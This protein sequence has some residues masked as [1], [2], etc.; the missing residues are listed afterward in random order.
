MAFNIGVNVVEVD[1]SA[2]PTIVAAPISVAGFLISSLRGIP[3][4]PVHLTGFADFVSS[5]GSYTPRFYG[6]HAARGF[7]D[8]GGTEAYAVRVVGR[9]NAAAQVTLDDPTAVASL[10]VKA[11][12]HGLADPGAWGNGLSVAVLDN[13]L[14]SSDIPAQIVGASSEPFALTDGD[15]LSVEVNGGAPTVVTFSAPDFGNI[16]AATAVEVATVVARSTTAF[17]A[18]VTPGNGL[19][20]ASSG[21]GLASRLAVSGPAAASLG[22]TGTTANSDT[23]LA[24]GTTSVALAATG[25]F[26]P[27]SAVRLESRG[28]VVGGAMAAS[29]TSGAGITITPDGGSGV[30]VTFTDADFAHGV[31]AI[32]P[33][34]VVAA[35]NRQAVGFTAGLT[36]DAHLVLC[37]DTFGHGSTIALAPPGGTTPDATA[38]LGLTGLTPVAGSRAFA[39]LSAVSETDRL[40]TLGT[41]LAGPVPANESRIQSIEFDL[42]VLQNGSEIERFA[43]L[44]MQSALATY[45]ETMVN[46]QDRGSRFV[47]VTDQHSTS[48]AGAGAPAVTPAPV[49]LTGGSDGST[50]S[51][52]DFMGDPAARTGLYAFDTVAIQL[53]CCPETTSAGV[54]SAA[55]AYCAGRGDAMFIGT[56]PQGYDLE[57]IKTY[58]APLRARKVYGALYAPWIQ[59]INPLDTTGANPQLTIPPVGHVAGM[60][61]RVG[62]ASGVW[63]A[64]AGDDAGLAFALGVEFDMTD[65]DHTDLVKNG[66]VNGVRAIPGSGIIVDASRTLSTDTRWLFVNVR[67]LFNFVKVSLR[68]GLRWVAQE[69]HDDELRRKVKFNVVTPFLLGLWRQGAFGSDPPAQVFTVIC[70]QTNNPP[71]QVDQGNFTVE[72]YF[73]PVKPAETIVIIVGQQESSASASEG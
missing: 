31:A 66:G 67:R 56:A 26:L 17:W 39:V 46:D 57:G 54:A 70:D 18:A 30:T 32:T 53:L 45:A 10:L 36:S 1:G 50:P 12:R 65:T 60:F 37:S 72:V 58:A 23:A 14:G 61:A 27:G 73:Y 43:S 44:S 8:N 2:A 33:D 59:V 22:F 68:D 5:F 52:L 4:L 13:P 71:E 69:P 20:L 51:E 29:L 63:K 62:E 6:A 11:G 16:G 48:G 28:H 9:G 49:P 42:V 3:N 21:P 40:V 24:T 25:G 35:I 34:E 19:V 15:T 38:D 41:G 55:L 64:P 47:V 7:F